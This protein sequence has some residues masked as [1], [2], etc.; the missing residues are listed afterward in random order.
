MG[1]AHKFGSGKSRVSCGDRQLGWRAFTPRTPVMGLGMTSAGGLSSREQNECLQ[2]ERAPWHLAPESKLSSCF[3]CC[4]V[5]LIHWR[6]LP[7]NP[8]GVFFLEV[9]VNSR[10]GE[11]KEK[12]REHTFI[13][14]ASI[15]FCFKIFVWDQGL[16]KECTKSGHI[17][18]L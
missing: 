16:L 7:L 14:L 1:D 13:L 8:G 15:E 12:G 11:G 4:E 3:L 5:H 6:R 10:E 18:G 2:G 9:S 17:W